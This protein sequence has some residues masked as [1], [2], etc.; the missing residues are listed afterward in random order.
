MKRLTEGILILS[1]ILLV[2]LALA[3]GNGLAQGAYAGGDN[4][5]TMTVKSGE[6]FTV[7]LDEN[8]T[9]GYS[10]NLTVGD[11]L[12]VVDSKY[13]PNATG[14]IGSGGYHI[15]TIKASK[16]GTYMVSG[17]YKR[18]WEATTGREQT[19]SLM[20][21]VT[22]SQGGS[23]MMPNMTFPSMKGLLDLKPKFTFNLSEMLDN[24]PLFGRH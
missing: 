24:F 23:T 4:G 7:K 17:I 16:A 19:Y 14:L 21:K 18:P 3:M 10:W 5:K 13:V 11:G 15:W 8:P 20:V 2:S 1:L 22:A 9:T 12:K 6:T